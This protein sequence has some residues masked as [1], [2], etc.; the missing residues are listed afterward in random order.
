[1]R[2]GARAA[3]AVCYNAARSASA[4]VRLPDTL[5]TPIRPAFSSH[6]AAQGGT[7]ERG[8]APMDTERGPVV[9]IVSP[10]AGHTADR[11]VL[12]HALRE[13]GVEVERVI[14]ITTLDE[15][16]PQG[17]QWK[18]AG[19]GAAVAAGGDGTVG[20][21]A[22]H[23]A[24][25][26]LP[27]G[28]LPVGTAN[29]VA[30]SLG[31]PLDVEAACQVVAHGQARAM[32]L[33]YARP[34]ETE[35][36]ALVELADGQRAGIH[37]PALERIAALAEAGAYFVHAATLGLNVDFARLAT[38]ATRRQ[39]LGRLTYLASAIQA[40]THFHAVPITVR[41]EGVTAEA[42]GMGAPSE[43]VRRG[44]SLN[45][46]QV[47][48][49]RVISGEVIQIAAV[50]T[51]VFGGPRNFRLQGVDVADRVLD[52]VVIEALETRHLKA[53]VER[54]EML[55]ATESGEADANTAESGVQTLDIPGIWRFQARAAR[56]IEPAELDVTLDGEIRA[57]TPLDIWTAPAALTVLVPQD[58]MGEQTGG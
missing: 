46:E 3:T 44:E 35:P 18:D 19:C 55:H 2:F 22:S 27:L 15:R 6:A 39:R 16:T 58:G 1:M 10:N 52:F 53:L 51:P 21:V 17:Q 8:R 54:F 37:T 26:G 50:I 28:I 33:G 45:V 47:D 42:Y 4:P 34:G 20:A 25:S 13:A 5:A 7:E 40:L 9:L 41:L 14:D 29:D 31:I 57:R 32:D 24:G 38:D 49:V 30:R 12:T 56:I 43:K 48:S 23:I 36:S 11:D